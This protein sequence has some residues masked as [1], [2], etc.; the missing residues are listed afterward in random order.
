[1]Q[2]DRPEQRR[3]P[4]REPRPEE[5]GSPAASEASLAEQP[6]ADGVPS[7][8]WPTRDLPPEAEAHGPSD[9]EPAAEARDAD[10]GDWPSGDRIETGIER[11]RRAAR[12]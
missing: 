5:D 10:A 11:E 9:A 7:A 12:D 8:S 6:S 1:M 3:E 4:G 2:D